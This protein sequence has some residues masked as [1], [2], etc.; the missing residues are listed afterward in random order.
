[1]NII[2]ESVKKLK[3]HCISMANLLTPETP[4]SMDPEQNRSYHPASRLKLSLAGR[5][6]A[7]NAVGNWEDSLHPAI[8]IDIVNIICL[9]SP[10]NISSGY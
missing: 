7:V 3:S 4:E 5:G 6:E 8:S 1:M 10:S 2:F 9:V